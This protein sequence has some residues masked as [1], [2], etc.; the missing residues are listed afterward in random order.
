MKY[1]AEMKRLLKE[2]GSKKKHVEVKSLPQMKRGRPPLLGENL[3]RQVISYIKEVREKKGIVTTAVTIASG[4]A[5]VN[6]V[7][8]GLLKENGGPI[9]LTS[10]WAKSIHQRI[11]FV[12][13]KVTTSAKVEPSHFKELKEQFL[14]DIKTVIDMEDV[15]SDL[16]LNWDHTGINV[17]PGSQWTME[18]K[19][20]KRVKAV[21]VNDKRQITVVLC[22]ALSGE[23]LPLQLIYQG[24]TSACLPRFVFPQDWNVTFT[25]NHWS[26]EQK[27][28]EYIEKII[29]QY[30]SEK[31]KAHGKPALVIF[32]EFKGQVT[33]DVYNMLDSNN[34]Q[35]VKVPPNC[36]DRL[37]PMDLSINKPVKDFLR[38]K[39]QKWYSEEVKKGYG[40]SVNVVPVDLRM[41]TMKPLGAGWLVG[42]YNYIKGKDSMVKNSF[43]AAGITD[44]ISKV[45]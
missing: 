4:E 31:C 10:V 32:D 24:K 3:D 14:L 16:I 6:K 33:D 41:S 11:N 2:S 23:L 5:I 20:S 36:T 42:A 15:P 37:Q 40:Q 28:K 44:I 45:L 39:F 30:V 18:A 43:K 8:K 26:N 27:T 13:R 22:A 19:G 34:I 17:V 29:L 21:G 38:D 7:N 9:E 35:V 1:V 12:K 25:P